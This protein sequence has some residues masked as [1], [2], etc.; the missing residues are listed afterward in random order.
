MN[1]LLSLKEHFRISELE[2][3]EENTTY[4]F[5]LIAFVNELQR[6]YEDIHIVIREM[7]PETAL[8]EGLLNIA[9]QFGIETDGLPDEKIRRMCLAAISLNESNGCS[10]L[11][12]HLGDLFDIDGT[13]TERNGELIYETSSSLTTQE[14]DH[15][16]Y[17]MKKLMPPNTD[18]TLNTV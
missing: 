15:I 2:F 12:E 9:A 6:L 13:L 11:W 7:F 1:A 16:L 8:S 4:Y 3:P 18:I 10:F 17:Q 14:A 5:E